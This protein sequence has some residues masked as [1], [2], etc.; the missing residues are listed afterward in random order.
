MRPS[1]RSGVAPFHVMDVL[2]AAQE[3]QRTHGDALFLCA[4]QPSTPAPRRA[5]A[6]VRDAVESEVLGY[7]EATGIPELK[8]AIADDHNRR[9]AARGHAG[10]AQ[11]APADV[12]VTTGSSGGFVTLFLAALDPGDDIV[13]ARPG[14]PAYRNALAAL[15]A[16]VVEID[17]GPETRFQLTVDLLEALERTPRAVIVTSPDN[18]TGTI[19]DGDELGRI[20]A[21]CEARDVLLISD[22]IY[23]GISF[24]RECVSAREFGDAAVVVGSVSKY[25]SMTGWRVGW[26]IIPEWLRGP[27]DRLAA[28][29]SVCPPA[30]SQRAAIEAFHPESIAELDGHV[31]RYADNRALL[32][33]RLPAAGLGTFAPPDGGFYVYADVSHLTDDSLAWARELLDATGVA[34]AP[35]VDFDVA[36]GHRWVRLCF[37]GSTEDMAEACRRIGEFNGR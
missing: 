35:G 30:A 5:L 15:G 7:T 10:A 26:L 32:M 20:A 3:R 16:N 27:C 4:G 17:C 36:A 8:R 24:G 25:H 33:E 19:I 9:M 11:V 29:L 13:L 31:R 34:V 37:A 28:N 22:E 21:W 2:A 23:H 18:P 14:Y 1:R 6:A 12:V